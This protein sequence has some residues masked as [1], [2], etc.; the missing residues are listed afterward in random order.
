MKPFLAILL[1]SI[2]LASIAC[3]SSA[4]PVSDSG[5][6][7]D[8]TS[9]PTATKTSVPTRAPTLPATATKIATQES[10]QAAE[11]TPAKTITQSIG[12]VAKVTNPGV[13]IVQRGDLG[14][15]AKEKIT[16]QLAIDSMMVANLMAKVTP[17]DD[18]GYIRAE[19]VP[20]TDTDFGGGQ[21]LVGSTR[22]PITTYCY[23]WDSNGTILSQ[24]EPGTL[25]CRATP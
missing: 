10:A 16:V 24:L 25:P 9:A 18:A 22:T 15:Q 4:A 7:G 5:E 17:N 8:P 20:A 3:G 19:G 12:E 6:T 21:T 1:A 13:P 11:P 23:T 14:A 2:L